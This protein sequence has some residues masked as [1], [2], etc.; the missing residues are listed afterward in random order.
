MFLLLPK[1]QTFI[2]IYSNHNILLI[3]SFLF[4]VLFINSMQ[5]CLFFGGGG[6][7]GGGGGKDLPTFENLEFH[8][9]QVKLYTCKYLS[10][11][12][13]RSRIPAIRNFFFIHFFFLL[14]KRNIS[15]C[16]PRCIMCVK[17]KTGGG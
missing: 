2:F 15:D 10:I 3:Y 4:L 16:L 7:G 13:F 5:Y 11:L 8:N 17:E 1:D 12:N 14:G 6:G 9:F